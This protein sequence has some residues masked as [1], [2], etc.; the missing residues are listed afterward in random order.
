MKHMMIDIETL[1]LNQGAAVLSIGAVAFDEKGLTGEELELFPEVCGAMSWSTIEWWFSQS[2]DARRRVTDKVR[3]SW[4]EVAKRLRDFEDQ[5]VGGYDEAVDPN[6]PRPK[7]WAL[8]PQF[9]LMVLQHHL[10]DNF[11]HYQQICDMRTLRLFFNHEPEKVLEHSA[12]HDARSQAK[13]VARAMADFNVYCAAYA[14][15]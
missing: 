11:W 13:W 7:V 3:I 14:R 6:E 15:G 4:H 12:L 1:S 2:E 9:D 10:P 8:G 5:L